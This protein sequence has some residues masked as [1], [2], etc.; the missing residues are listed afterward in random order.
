MSDFVRELNNEPDQELDLKD[1]AIDEK[2]EQ[3]KH[4]RLA[5]K[6][7]LIT[8][9]YLGFGPIMSQFAGSLYGFVNSFWIAR[10]LGEFALTSFSIAT[11]FDNIGRAFGFFLSVAASSKI[12]ALFALR[13]DSEVSQVIVDL[14][15]VAVI[16]G[17]FVAILMCILEPIAARWIGA[18]EE[19]VTLGKEYI[20]PIFIGSFFTCGFLTL[21]GSLQAEGRTTLVGVTT[22]ISLIICV[23]GFVP[24]GIYGLK[25]GMISVGVFTILGEVIPFFYFLYGYFSGKFSSKPKWNQFLKPFNSNTWPALRVGSSQ[26]LANLS[27]SIPGI[28]MRKFLGVS[29][30]ELDFNDIIAAYNIFIRINLLMNAFLIALGMG[31]LPAASYSFAAENHRRFFQLT[32]HLVWISVVWCILIWI[33]SLAIPSEMIRMFDSGTGILD[34]GG[35]IIFYGNV[36]VFTVF[37]RFNFQ[38]ILQALGLSFRASVLSFFS[39]FGAFFAA[40][41]LL[42]YTDEHNPIRLLSSYWISYVAGL[43][44]G[45]C[46]LARPIYTIFLLSKKD[47]SQTPSQSSRDNIGNIPLS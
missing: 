20:F 44:L 19:I 12:S 39:Q 36:A 14:L 37:V 23:F 27:I 17:V 30:N 3:L 26:L 32:Y 4:E 8:I 11:S 34:W 47:S 25:F 18:T 42:F 24:L 5:G 43:V 15:R 7:P 35:K 41:L 28:L 21:S 6:K 1:E 9:F 29:C 33:L 22:L 16:F 38:P 10:G 31:Y 13:N 2:E 40:M 46:L 45:V